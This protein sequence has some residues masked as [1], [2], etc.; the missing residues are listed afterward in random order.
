MREM[1]TEQRKI[2]RGRFFCGCYLTQSNQVAFFRM[3]YYK[4]VCFPLK[5]SCKESSLCL[6]QLSLIRAQAAPEEVSFIMSPV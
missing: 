3:N 6:K 4:S 1:R 2:K 5:I